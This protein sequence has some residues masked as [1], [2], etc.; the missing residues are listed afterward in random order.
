MTAVVV[1][2]SVDSASVP[3][4]SGRSL[5]LT[6][7]TQASYRSDS[8]SPSAH[9]PSSC[10]E[11]DNEEADAW[12]NV[13]VADGHTN[14]RVSAVM[15]DDDNDDV[16]NDGDFLDTLG[17]IPGAIF[18]ALPVLDLDLALGAADSNVEFNCEIWSLSRLGYL[19]P[20]TTLFVIKLDHK[21]SC[22]WV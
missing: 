21:W 9:R 1:P 7:Q 20:E 6:A 8:S 15:T 2:G 18:M 14:V 13:D 5:C 11:V 12:A 3:L 17:E 19:Y 22:L 10:F 16:A 4:S